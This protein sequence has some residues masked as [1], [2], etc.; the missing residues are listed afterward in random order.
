MFDFV[1][2]KIYPW[3][4]DIAFLIFLLNIIIFLPLSLF[5]K[6]RKITGQ[7]ILYSSYFIG[8]QLWL[9]GIMITWIAW[10]IG[11]VIVGLF[12]AGVGVVPIAVFAAFY[13]AQ[14]WT[15]FELL[16]QIFIVFGGR[17]LGLYILYK[18]V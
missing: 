14:W 12:F 17:A 18:S 8:F 7:I 13:H 10:G 3:I 1:F 9:S 5:K 16:S 4:S 6:L 11:A 2:G 15:F